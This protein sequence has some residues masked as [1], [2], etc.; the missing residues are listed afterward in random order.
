M[1][2]WQR[3][4]DHGKCDTRVPL[5][6]RDGR[7]W[8]PACQPPQGVWQADRRSGAVPL[9]RNKF[10]TDSSQF[11]FHLKTHFSLFC[12]TAAAATSASAPSLIS[13]VGVC[14]W[15]TVSVMLTDSR[16]CGRGRSW[17]W[18]LRELKLSTALRSFMASFS[19]LFRR[20]THSFNVSEHLKS[21][22][23]IKKTF[24][25]SFAVKCANML[26]TSP[27]LYD[28]IIP[29]FPHPP[30]FTSSSTVTEIIQLA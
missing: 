28:V 19:S 20:L 12:W 18:T 27:F 24:W 1:S 5:T 29:L 7:C 8:Q 6:G 21:W 22:R 4:R 13:H 11:N 16:Q 26:S 23:K 30:C 2:F 17:W 9:W 10:F 15:G 3:Q 25:C 14:A